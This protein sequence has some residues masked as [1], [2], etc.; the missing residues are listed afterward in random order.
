MIKRCAHEENWYRS[1]VAYN[2]EGGTNLFDMPLY[3]IIDSR[4]FSAAEYFAFITKE[5]KRGTILGEKTPGGGHP[6]SSTIIRNKFQV[7]V[8]I[9]EIRTKDGKDLEGQGVSPDVELTSEDWIKEA[10]EYVN[11]NL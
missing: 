1:E 10:A 5:M 8:P 2:Y 4:T 7:Y 9:C 11:K 3:V 6:I